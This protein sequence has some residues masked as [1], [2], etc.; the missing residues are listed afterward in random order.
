M[1]KAYIYAR[2]S[3]DEQAEE[4][5]SIE[6]QIKLCSNYA[7]SN[8][9]SLAGQFIDEGK[10]ATT[11]NRPALKEMLA[12]CEEDG[13]VDIILI[14]DTDRLARN[15]LDHLTIKSIL[16]KQDIQL[17]SISQL[18]LDDSPEGNLIDTILASVNAFQ[19]QITGRKTSKVMEEKAK[20]GWYPGGLPALG[21]KNIDNPLPSSTLDK[22][23]IT[24]DEEVAPHIKKIFE[25]YAKGDHSMQDLV[26]YLRSHNIRS[27]H[28]ANI[29]ISLIARIL[30]DNFYLGKFYWKAVEYDGKHEPLIT[31]EV[32][33]RV[34]DMLIANTQNQ[35][36]KRVHNF[37]LRGFLICDECGRRYWGE[38][39]K[40][41]S[42][43]VFRY[44]FCPNC[45][46]DTYI[47]QEKLEQVIEKEFEQI[48]LSKQYVQHVLDTAHKLLEEIRG[49]Q[50]SEKKR[51]QAERTKV[52]KAMRELED[53]RS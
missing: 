49:S 25:M 12:K 36:R 5:K 18:M 34:Q 20:T 21:Y 28:N 43:L 31:Q 42:G 29:H 13:I 4:G 51:I 9:I 6:T 30:R 16:K 15:T 24:L 17:I 45:K 53:S 14:Q 37:L 32:F 11:I 23:I 27:S 35:S 39:H 8:G 2:V 1:K 46:K 47:D 33:D 50:D 44:Y 38:K 22:R 26:D 48:Q 19:S 3:T 40:K 7:K 52:E 41:P 10:S